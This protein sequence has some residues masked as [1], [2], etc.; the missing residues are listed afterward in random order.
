LRDYYEVLGVSRDA[1]DAQIKKAFRKLARE[2]HPDVNAH[3]PQAEEKFKE[4]G[5]AYEVLSDPE[6]R[7]VYDAFG[8]EGLRSGGWSPQTAGFGAVQD[9]LETLFGAEPVMGDLF[10]FGRRGPAPGGHVGARVEVTLDEVLSGAKREVKFDAATV[11]DRCGGDGAEPGS[12]V[13]TCPQCQGAGQIREVSQT[14][15]GQVIRAQTCGRCGGM[16]RVPEKPCETCGGAGR[17]RGTRT[18]EV[19]VPPGIESGQRIRVA[20]GGHA[21]EAGASAGDLYVEVIVKPDERFRRDGEDLICA[22]EVP[23]T[24]AMLG[25][26]LPVPTLDGE[27]EVEAPAGTQ[28][29][30]VAVLEGQG[31]PVLGSEARGDIRVVFDVVVPKRL[32]KE[33][34][35]LAEELDS[36][37]GGA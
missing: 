36:A 23:V 28:P 7:R 16:G 35:R 21:G 2:L 29:G 1:D 15:F 32:N 34:R 24:K 11:C 22:V 12:E 6:R 37:I 25:G 31:L 33:Q 9:I 3:D 18:W 27:R 10:G 4:A 20:G 19:Q 8:H 13:I 14:V 5:E 26:T 17:V 30:D